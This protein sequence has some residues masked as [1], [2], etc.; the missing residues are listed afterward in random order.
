[1]K[2]TIKSQIGNG[3]INEEIEFKGDEQLEV[4]VQDNIED[5]LDIRGIP[6]IV[7]LFSI[8]KEDDELVVEADE[9]LKELLREIEKGES[10]DGIVY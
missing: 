5:A 4:Y 10:N 2:I 1:M 7:A 3:E 6:T 8:L 9:E